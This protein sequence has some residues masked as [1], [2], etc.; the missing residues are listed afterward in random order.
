MKSTEDIEKR[1]KN[2]NIAIDSERNKKVFS[3]ILQA[4]EKSKAKELAPTGQHIRRVILKSPLAKIAAA[5]VIIIAFGSFLS[6]DRFTPKRST[7]GH[8]MVAKSSIKMI[9]MIS[10]RMAYQRG[11]IDEL[12]QQLQD[13][14]ELLGPSSSSISMKELLEGVNGS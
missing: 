13:T 4:F 10:L 7:P 11:G 6:R 3:D 9:S 1:I 12:E 2:V 8:P 5:A 14:L